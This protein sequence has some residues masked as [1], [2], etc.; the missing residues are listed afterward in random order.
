[1]LYELILSDRHNVE[2]V[3]VA[4][5]QSVY[6]EG[7]YECEVDGAVYPGPRSVEQ[8]EAGQWELGCPICGRALVPGWT[9]E[10]VLNPHN[11]YGL[12]KRD[13][14]DLATQLGL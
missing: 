12:S 11:P 10:S 7:R 8:L 6:G 5:S 3:V 4:S 13:Q 2:L 1:M 9:D 14:D